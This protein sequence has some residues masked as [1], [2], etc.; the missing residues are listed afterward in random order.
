VVRVL[1]CDF[2]GE[3]AGNLALSYF[4]NWQQKDRPRRSD[5]RSRQA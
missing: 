4:G 5:R 3:E 2:D 1:S